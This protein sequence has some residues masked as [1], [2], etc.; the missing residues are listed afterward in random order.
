M[1]ESDPE[2]FDPES[3]DLCLYAPWG[4][5]SLFYEDFRYSEGLISLGKLETGVE[6]LGAIEG[7]FI[8]R[9]EKA[10]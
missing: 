2:G 3:G 8:V 7:D 1:I 10:E 6:I 5:L 4:N 9:I